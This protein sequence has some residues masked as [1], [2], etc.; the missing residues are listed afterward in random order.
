M[1]ALVLIS[2]L[3]RVA[4]GTPLRPLDDLLRV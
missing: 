1:V 4:L 3:R 2:R